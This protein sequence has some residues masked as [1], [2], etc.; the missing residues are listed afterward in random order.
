VE[1]V[2]KSARFNGRARGGQTMGAIGTKRK[3]G[4]SSSSS[5]LSGEHI[6][7]L[8]ATSEMAWST[9]LLILIWGSSGWRRL[10]T[11][12]SCHPC[13]HSLSYS[14]GQSDLSHSLSKRGEV[15]GDG[16]LYTTYRNVRHSSHRSV[17]NI[18]KSRT[19]PFSASDPQRPRCSWLPACGM[20]GG[21]P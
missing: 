12:A 3:K 10:C 6:E 13:R 21:T 14:Q 19:F 20:G 18:D 8:S 17:A 15:Y 11:T 5:Q 4:L 16:S 9:S 2:Y 1:V 7:A